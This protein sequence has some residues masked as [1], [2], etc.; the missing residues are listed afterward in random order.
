[1]SEEELLVPN[2]LYL[3]AGIHIGTKFKTKFMDNFIYK[4]RSDGLSVL[5]VQ[6]I[7]ERIKEMS[8]M[9]SK[10][11]P[12]DILVV[13]RRENGWQPVKVFGKIIGAKI[14]AGR[15]PP[16]I[17]TNPNLKNHMEAKIVV[18]TDA[19][20]DRNAVQDALKI[21]IPVIALCDTNN[22]ANNIDLVVP[23]NNKGKKSLG[24]LFYIVAREYMKSR[25]TAEKDIKFTVEEFTPE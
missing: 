23:C 17:L 22:Q 6:K 10:Y 2:D 4:T 16:G 19:W 12:Q 8:N 3:K 18:V 1:M 20:P 24:L 14:F 9:L 7:D 25:G 15:Y 13:S 11:E 21:G 5:N